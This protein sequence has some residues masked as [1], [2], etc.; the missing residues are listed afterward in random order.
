MANNVK[1]D[2]TA[3]KTLK[4]P[5]FLRG[6]SVVLLQFFFTCFL[7]SEGGLD[8]PLF[9]MGRMGSLPTWHTFGTHRPLPSQWPRKALS[10]YSPVVAP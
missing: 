4:N 1:A 3:Q 10:D 5:T 7:V 6:F 8:H 9:L 2:E